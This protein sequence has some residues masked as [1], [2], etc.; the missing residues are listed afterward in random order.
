VQRFTPTKPCK[1]CGGIERYANRGL[2]L[3]DCVVCSIAA[4]K[5]KYA[6]NPDKANKAHAAWSSKNPERQKKLDAKSYLKWKY[7]LTVERWTSML[8]AQTGRCWLCDLPMLETPCVDHDHVT[9]EIR[10]LAHG[11]CNSAFGLLR[12]CSKTLY[13]LA[14]K[15]KSLDKKSKTL[16]GIY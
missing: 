10:G 11:S 16:K 1:K 2:R 6:A 14:D 4:A 3:G 15:A 13:A 8:I 5:R 7:G 9:D 12:E